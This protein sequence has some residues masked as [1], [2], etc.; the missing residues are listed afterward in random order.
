MG[1]IQLIPIKG[2]I[3]RCLDMRAKEF[4]R[5]KD[6]PCAARAAAEV[7]GGREYGFQARIF[8]PILADPEDAKLTLSNMSVWQ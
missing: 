3:G 2:P 1:P 5:A 7:G 6:R 4:R 8:T